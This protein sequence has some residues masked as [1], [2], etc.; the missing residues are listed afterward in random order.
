MDSRN[1]RSKLTLHRVWLSYIF[2][3]LFHCFSFLIISNENIYNLQEEYCSL[4]LYIVF[5]MATIFR[6]VFLIHGSIFEANL[7]R[8]LISDILFLIFLSRCVEFHSKIDC[9]DFPFQQYWKF[10][11]LEASV[12]KIQTVLTLHKIISPRFINETS[13]RDSETLRGV[14]WNLVSI[15]EN[16]ERSKRKDLT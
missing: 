15:S 11:N 3:R 10:C 13:V 7:C 8:T 12:F 4:W 5:T 6:L 14:S 9:Q 16:F 2:Q 1:F